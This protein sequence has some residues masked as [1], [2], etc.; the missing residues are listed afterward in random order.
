MGICACQN[1]TNTTNNTTSTSE[2]ETLD[3]NPHAEGFN[4][5]NSDEEAIQLADQVM[6][7]HG[8]RKAWDN[9][10]LIIWNFFGRRKLYWNKQSGDVRI[11]FTEN[12]LKIIL[13]EKSMEGRVFKDG[14]EFS[15]PD[16]IKTYL[17]RGK[18]IWINDSYWLVMPF[19]LKD[20]GVTLKYLREDTTQ[21][22]RKAKVLEL[23]FENVGDTPE[24][25]YEIFVDSETQMVSQWSFF[26]EATQDSANFT[27]PWLDYKEHGAIKLSGNRGEMELTEIQVLDSIPQ[28]LFSSF[29]AVEL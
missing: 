17:E 10:Q 26:K 27:I 20:S 29:E 3:A 23:T 24:N 8:G 11:D 25:K 19:K 4:L 21:N 16:S 2:A 22:G 5:E 9:T 12:D 6:E 28:G 13:N 15:E 7:A 18:S 1:N 14:Q